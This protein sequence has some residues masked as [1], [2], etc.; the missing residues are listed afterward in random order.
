M[1]DVLDRLTATIDPNGNRTEFEY[2]AL[3]ELIAV[4]DAANNETTCCY[5]RVQKE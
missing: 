3:D 2:N 5:Y 1:Y 4:I